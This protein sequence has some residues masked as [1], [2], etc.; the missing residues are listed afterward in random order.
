MEILAEVIPLAKSAYTQYHA[1]TDRNIVKKRDQSSGF[2]ADT[3]VPYKIEDLI[4]ILDERMG[5]LEN[6]TLR[7]TYHRLI[8]RI[9]TVRN[10]PRYAFMFDNAN[11]GGD[12]MADILTQLFRLTSDGRPMTIMQMAG[13]PAEV[14]DSVVSVLCRMAFDFGLWSDGV[15]PAL[16]CRRGAPLRSGQF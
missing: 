9:Q 13:F 11:I 12:T 3:P 2:T 4:N 7:V 15:S 5:K 10:H 14:I 16:V 6:R 1:S 8:A